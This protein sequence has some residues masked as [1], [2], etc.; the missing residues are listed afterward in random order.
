MFHINW[1]WANALS[2]NAFYSLNS[3]LPKKDEGTTGALAYNDYHQAVFG[4]APF[5]TNSMRSTGT[6]NFGPLVNAVCS[7][8]L[9]EEYII[10]APYDAYFYSNTQVRI[11]DGCW[12][13]AGSKVHIAI[14]DLPCDD[15][16][17]TR[18]AP[19][20]HKSPSIENKEDTIID[21]SSSA[22]TTQIQTSTTIDHIAVHNI[23]GQLLQTIYGNDGKL[24]D[25]PCGL[26]ILQKH[27]TDGSVV[28]ET[29][30]KN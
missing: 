8:I 6:Q 2:N 27:I 28:S 3:L 25:L 19:A 9:L 10:P 4:I 22:T 5:I 24:S 23:S 11:A 26:Y 1:G 13:K 7:G 29:I 14:K 16:S 30:V 12:F 20:V 17:G 21:N 15:Y 18:S